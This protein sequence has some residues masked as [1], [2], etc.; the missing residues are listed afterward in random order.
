MLSDISH[1]QRVKYHMFS[2]I[3]E[4]LKSSSYKQKTEWLF[5]GPVDSG[6]I[7]EWWYSNDTKWENSSEP[8]NFFLEVFLTIFLHVNK[9]SNSP[10]SYSIGH[11]C[12]YLTTT[13]NDFSI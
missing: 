13:Y 11:H 7:K 2:F 5:P 4:I 12:S 10:E 1:T 9:W 3:H 8:P 6:G